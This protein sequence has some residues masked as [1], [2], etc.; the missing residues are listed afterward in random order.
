MEISGI[1]HEIKELVFNGGGAR[2]VGMPGVYYALKNTSMWEEEKPIWDGIE[3]LAGT[4]VGSLTAA[5]FSVSPEFSEL[6]E[7]I[8]SKNLLDIL[9]IG[10]ATIPFHFSLEPLKNFLNN[11]LVN[12]IQ[13]YLKSEAESLAH[14]NDDTSQELLRLLDELKENN[15]QITFNDLHL[16]SKKYPVKFKNMIVTSTSSH[17]GEKILHIY[18]ANKT[19]NQS[20]AEACAASSALPFIFKPVH[21]NG[22]RH[23][24]G[25]CGDPLPSEYFEE[26]SP[27]RQA[28]RL[29]FVF[30][31]GPSL[32]GRIWQRTL[33]GHPSPT[34]N[35][36]TTQ[37]D[38]LQYTRQKI[39]SSEQ[40][41]KIVSVWIDNTSKKVHYFVT[42]S[43]IQS[44]L[45][46]DELGIPEDKE[47]LDNNSFTPY[48]IDFYTK[49]TLR[50][51]M[52]SILGNYSPIWILNYFSP[53]IKLML[54][55]PLYI[56]TLFESLCQRL[57]T[58]Y[59]FNTITLHTTLLGNSFQEGEKIKRT[60]IAL[61][62]L[63]TMN[64]LSLYQFANQKHTEFD[65]SIFGNYFIIYKALLKAQNVQHDW[66]LS[67]YSK[68]INIR[69]LYETVKEDVEQNP[70]SLRAFA[71][72]CAVELYL[73]QKTQEDI[74]SE[75][76]EKAKEQCQ[77]YGR[78]FYGERYTPQSLLITHS[79]GT[80]ICL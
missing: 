19:P 51:H 73:E 47:I 52:P 17:Q 60:A 38:M 27:E 37:Q 35:F 8:L 10:N 4:S 11:Y 54:G 32:L 5:L 48:L 13:K 14:T 53:V 6:T 29:L 80:Q 66:Y 1:N 33:H 49:L 41:K 30:G 36:C 22:V 26:D 61:Y 67:Q 45:T 56:A 28:K 2:G 74:L 75:I 40:Y 31:P 24:D 65:T 62:Y 34:F 71:L 79:A 21:L 15:H 7:E 18:S 72:T 16:L 9:E 20:I 78:F 43:N 77:R 70:T 63:D 3:T 12:H 76:N 69:A 42:E 59:T 64:H 25:G 50:K 55:F 58:F 39:E 46:F 57:R 68:G 44:F 23:L